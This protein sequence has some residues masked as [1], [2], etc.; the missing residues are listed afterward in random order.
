[1]TFFSWIPDGSAQV[2]SPWLGLYGGLTVVLTVVTVMLLN[3][4]S[5]KEMENAKETLEKELDQ[6]SD[7]TLFSRFSFPRSSSSFRS[8]D[9]ELG[10]VSR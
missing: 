2:I 3:K 8:K 4:W 7:S 10:I 9:V 6:D 1:M 5:N